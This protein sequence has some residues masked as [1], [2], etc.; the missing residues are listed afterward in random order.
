MELIKKDNQTKVDSSNVESFRAKVL[1]ARVKASD[2]I[3][4]NEFLLKIENTN[5]FSKGDIS[6]WVG[7][8]KSK[9][10]F[11]LTMFCAAIIGG[12]RLYGKFNANKKARVLWIDTE[13]S[14]SDVQRVTKRI[15]SLVGCE[16]G[17]FMYGLRPLSPAQR[18]EAIGL[19]LEEHKDIEVLIIDGVRDLLMD[20]NNAVE[21]TEVMTLLM[22]W[23][24]ELDI[25]VAVVLHVNPKDGKARGHIGTELM[26]KSQ[27]VIRITKDETDGNISWVEEVLGRGKGFDKFSFSVDKKGLP[28][29]V[30]PIYSYESDEDDPPY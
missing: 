10:T 1:S 4:Q 9:K 20:V 26:N 14:P 21:C 17:L 16:I 23:S 13:Q 18:I 28:V 8:A 11:A 12:L 29:I 19:L 24:Y 5:K 3:K 27:T 25:H 30:E 15:K 7:Q 6:G 22:K 2:D